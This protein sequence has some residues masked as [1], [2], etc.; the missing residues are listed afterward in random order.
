MGMGVLPSEL[1]I[2]EHIRLGSSSVIISRSFHMKSETIEDFKAQ[3]FE[4][5]IRKLKQQIS[6]AKDRNI[7]QI[8]NDKINLHV[9]IG[10]IIGVY[11]ETT[12]W[13][14]E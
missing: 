5:E 2:A 11:S 6:I 3:N 14:F 12:N 10:K 7:S 13:F 8:Y 4:H 1:V 9:A